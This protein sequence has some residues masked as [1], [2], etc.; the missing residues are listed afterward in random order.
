MAKKRQTRRTI[1]VSGATYARI[2]TWCEQQD[3]SVSGFVE[4]TLIKALNDINAPIPES[5]APVRPKPRPLP[6]K[7]DPFPGSY[8]TF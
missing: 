5:F 8:F 2:H 1:S 6:P 3:V 4:R 7:A